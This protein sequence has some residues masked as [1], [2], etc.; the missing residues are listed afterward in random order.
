MG[1]LKIGNPQAGTDPRPPP[2]FLQISGLDSCSRDYLAAPKR[3]SHPYD[4]F[5]FKGASA[6]PELPTMKHLSKRRDSEARTGSPAVRLKL[7]QEVNLAGWKAT[8]MDV[9]RRVLW[10]NPKLASLAHAHTELVAPEPLL[11]QRQFL[12]PLAPCHGPLPTTS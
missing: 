10:I 12:I 8:N 7:L 4:N 9:P 1:C 6:K 5:T 3:G 2:G 11:L